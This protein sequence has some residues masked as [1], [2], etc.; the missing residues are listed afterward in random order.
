M[1]TMPSRISAGGGFQFWFPPRNDLSKGTMGGSMQLNPQAHAGS[2]P[3]R[4]GGVA[5]SL[6]AKLDQESMSW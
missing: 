5:K 3:K 2:R 6:V 4:G 1:F